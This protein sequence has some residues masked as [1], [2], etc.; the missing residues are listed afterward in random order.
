MPHV[1]QKYMHTE[2]FWISFSSKM[3]SR[4]FLS[5]KSNTGA[6]EIEIQRACQKSWQMGWKIEDFSESV[7]SFDLEQFSSLH[8]GN[9]YPGMY[10]L[11]PSMR[12]RKFPQ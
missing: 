10:S 4:A 9:S 7:N 11:C 2:L 5:S 1:F 6:G 3:T 12:F 8:Q